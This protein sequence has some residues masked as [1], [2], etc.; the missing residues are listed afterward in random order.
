MKIIDCA[1]QFYDVAIRF[2]G[3]QG[4]GLGKN[5]FV[6]QKHGYQNP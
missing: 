2:G 6:F 4:I 1:A 5:M 3:N